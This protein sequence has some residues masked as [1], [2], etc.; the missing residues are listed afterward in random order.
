[1]SADRPSQF[2]WPPLLLVLSIVAAWLLNRFV[3]LAWPG[4][5]DGPARMV[6]YGFGILGVGLLFWA[7]ATLKRHETTVMP[8]QPSTVLVTVGPYTHLRNPIYLADV[9]IMFGLAELSQNIWFV[10]MALLFAVAVTWLA[11]LP[12]EAHL[13]A[14]FGDN[15]LKYK[16][17]TRRWI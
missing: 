14:R 3:P 13:E 11:I 8:H 9:F 5:N 1:M 2:P 12:E 4:L 17:N 6:G 16:S 15:Y 10:V 7:I